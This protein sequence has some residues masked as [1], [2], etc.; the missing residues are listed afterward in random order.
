M[1]GAR[2]AKAFNTLTAGYQREVAEGRVTGP[3]AMFYA[4]EVL[5]RPV[6]QTS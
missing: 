3:V 4:S 6:Q 2:I 5:M 1:P